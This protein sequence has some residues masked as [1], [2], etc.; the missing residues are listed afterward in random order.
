VPNGIGDLVEL[1]VV[2]LEKGMEDAALHGLEAILKIG[3]GA[4]LDDIGGV[5]EEVVVE[6]LFKVCHSLIPK[7]QR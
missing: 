3:Y 6:K 1:A 2:H 7:D 4:V 5:I